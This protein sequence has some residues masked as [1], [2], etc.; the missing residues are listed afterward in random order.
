MAGCGQFKEAGLYP[1]LRV[2][3]TEGNL[4]GLLAGEADLK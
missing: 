4:P 3:G 1:Y 2:Y